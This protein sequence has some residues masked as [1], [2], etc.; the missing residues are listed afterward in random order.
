VGLE[1]TAHNDLD[2]TK[3]QG[4]VASDASFLAS[5]T[6]NPPATLHEL[7]PGALTKYKSDCNSGSTYANATTGLWIATGALATAG[8]VSFIVG[9]RQAAHAKERRR[10]ALWQQSLR[11]APIFSH[12]GGGITAA[13]EF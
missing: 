1:E 11:V 13:F 2:K 3:V 4:T 10:A 6:C 7:Q 9:D 12:Q 5:P 8:I